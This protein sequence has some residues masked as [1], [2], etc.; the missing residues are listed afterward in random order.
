M[1]FAGADATGFEDRHCTPYYSYRCSLRHSYT[2]MSAGSYMKTQLVCAVVIQH[3]PISH[4]IMHFPQML[5]QMVTVATPWIFVLDMGY[6]AEWV[7]QMIRQHQILSMIP[8]RKREDCPIYRTRGR[9][10]KQMRR[11]FDDTLYHQRNKC[12]TIFSVIKRRF[13]S[14]IKSYHDTMKEKELLYRVLAY[15]CH[16][17]CV[18]SC[19]LWMIS[20]KP[21]EIIFNLA[22]QH[23]FVF[24]LLKLSIL[25]LL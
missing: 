4:D 22:F 19:L 10:R 15:N 18:I 5:E 8:V 9:Y 20:R 14:E 2:K 11:K 21:G 1:I 24:D 7:H 13:G 3:H 16:R 6:D 12:E 25:P 17:M 23:L